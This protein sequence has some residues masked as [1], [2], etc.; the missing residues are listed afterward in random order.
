ML[1]RLSVLL[2]QRLL[3]RTDPG[4]LAGDL[5]GH[6]L[7]NLGELGL[8]RCRCLLCFL[9]LGLPANNLLSMFCELLLQT[10]GVQLRLAQV[11][12]ML[13]RLSVLLRQRLLQRTDPGGLAGDLFGHLLFNLGEL[14]LKRC[15]CLLCFLQLGLAVNNLLRTSCELLLQTA[16]G[17]LSRLQLRFVLAGFCL[18]L[19]QLSLQ[20]SDA[21]RLLARLRRC[22]FLKLRDAVL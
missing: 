1:L 19:C 2:R 6:L 5:F 20:L 22:T 13:L 10:C 4:G 8:K 12:F 15:R 3:Q 7:F 14:G 9:Q 16:R 11:V 17:L 21:L 18:L